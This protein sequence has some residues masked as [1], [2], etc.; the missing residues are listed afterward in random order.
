MAL[1]PDNLKD[2]PDGRAWYRDFITALNDVPNVSRACRAASISRQTAY[3]AREVDE[4]FREAWDDCIEASLD[5]L[6][7]KMIDRGKANDTVAGIFMLKAH[8]PAKYRETTR[9]EHSGPDGEPLT[10]ALVDKIIESSE[11]SDGDS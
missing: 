4:R 7:E 8:R 10:I 11:D 9:H 2:A 6:E 3:E 5:E 1:Q